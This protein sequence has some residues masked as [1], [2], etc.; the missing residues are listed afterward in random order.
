MAIL[1]KG[2]QQMIDLETLIDR[3]GMKNVLYALAVIANEKAEHL[4]LNWQD[5]FLSR[6][7]ERNAAKI[8]KCARQLTGTD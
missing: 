1:E 6:T 7:W 3:V 2:N 5:S 4:A 8:E